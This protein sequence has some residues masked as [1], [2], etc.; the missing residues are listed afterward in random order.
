MKDKIV[1]FILILIVIAIMV[2]IGIFGYTIYKEIIASDENFVLDF[3]GIR[4]FTKRK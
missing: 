2:A 3:Q 1:S 4:K